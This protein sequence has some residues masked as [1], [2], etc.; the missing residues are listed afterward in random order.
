VEQLKDLIDDLEIQ[1]VP[2]R[3]K[4]SGEVQRFKKF[5]QMLLGSKTPV[6]VKDID[7]RNYAKFILQEGAMDE[8]RE[9][10]R[11]LKSEIF[12]VKKE[13]KLRIS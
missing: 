2:M 9:F 3:D 10:M 13:V 7:I 5:E 1:T 6:S 12:L 8:K 4:I 11:C